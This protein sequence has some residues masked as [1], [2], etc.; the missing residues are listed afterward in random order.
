MVLAFTEHVFSCLVSA[1]EGSCLITFSF[2]L[3]DR[4]VFDLFLFLFFVSMSPDSEPE[5][6]VEIHDGDSTVEVVGDN[7]SVPQRPAI[8]QSIFGFCIQSCADSYAEVYSHS[9]FQAIA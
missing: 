7:F 6:H 8:P 2:A 5:A 1:S 3:A 4:V 9:K